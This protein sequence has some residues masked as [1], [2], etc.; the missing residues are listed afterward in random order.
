MRP[1]E[2]VSQQEQSCCAGVGDE[3]RGRPEGASAVADSLHP[4]RLFLP[5][6]PMGSKMEVKSD[7]L[8]LGSVLLIGVE[9]LKDEPEYSFDGSHCC[10]K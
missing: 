4:V 3:Y 2:R 1:P 8:V 5:F 10:K 9:C 6:E 7:S